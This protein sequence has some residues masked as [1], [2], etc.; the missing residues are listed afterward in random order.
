MGSHSSSLWLRALLLSA[1]A[2]SAISACTG[3]AG[4]THWIARVG[5]A[6]KLDFLAHFVAGTPREGYAATYIHSDQAQ[7]VVV[8]IGADDGMRAWL[9]G[10]MLGE[11]STC[12][13]VVNDQFGFDATLNQGWNRLLIKVRDHGGGWGL[14]ARFLDSQGEPIASRALSLMPGGAYTDNQRDA[15]GDGIG[16]LCDPAPGTPGSQ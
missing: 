13:G 3:E 2:I 7:S 12:Q 14:S 1:A 10:T 6:D 16:D 11:V 15:D 8:S 4:M 5:G 9:N